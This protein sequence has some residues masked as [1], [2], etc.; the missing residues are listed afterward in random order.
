MLVVFCLKFHRI[1]QPV[2][3]SLQRSYTSNILSSKHQNDS[4]TSFLGICVKLLTDVK[5]STPINSIG[6][7]FY[8][9]CTNKTNTQSGQIYSIN[10]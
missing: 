2:V 1:F 4:F 5:W 3:R 7:I 9:Q 8:R 10:T 6:Y